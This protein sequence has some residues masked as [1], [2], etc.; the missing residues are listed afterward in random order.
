M[1]LP[2]NWSDVGDFFTSRE[3]LVW[4][5]GV[6]VVLGSFLGFVAAG[7]PGSVNNCIT[8]TGV[9]LAPPPAKDTPK[10][11]QR[12]LDTQAK[13]LAANTCYCEAFNLEDVVNGAPGVR[14]PTNTWSNLYAVVSSLVVAW[15]VFL[16]RKYSA[17]D[18]TNPIRSHVWIPLAYIFVLQFL[19][20]GS[21]WLHGAL[22]EW[23]GF[24]DDFSMYLFVLF[25]VFYTGYRLG[26]AYSLKWSIWLW[27]G[28]LPIVILVS[29]V[30]ELI[31]QR[32]PT[33]PV[34]EVIIIILGSIYGV[35][36]G[37]YWVWYW[38]K[39]SEWTWQTF[40]L[41]IRQTFFLWLGA[42]ASFGL[43]FL[44]WTLSK[45]GKPWCWPNSW[46]QLHG[47][48]WHLMAGVM[49]LLIYLFWRT[50]G[51]RPQAGSA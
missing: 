16:D 21:M 43:A 28:Y 38:W 24:T 14:Q 48:G 5:L 47:L 18:S 11:R 26:V 8:S 3:F 15:L 29:A 35:L 25:L 27:L 34:S 33:K 45:T 4:A 1:W 50:E 37:W 20:L 23:G 31:S 41:W 10:E 51:A 42:L 40:F 6:F 2:Q 13:K 32:N 12:Y 46:F 9:S 30:G 7:W 22:K 39:T 17:G 49:A 19:G 44:F 36:Q